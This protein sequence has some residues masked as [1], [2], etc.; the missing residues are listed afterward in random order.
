MDTSRLGWMYDAQHLLN[1]KYIL[2][3][4]AIK[5][6]RWDMGDVY[7]AFA[8]V[9][10][11]IWAECCRVYGMNMVEEYSTFTLWLLVCVCVWWFRRIR[12][13]FHVSLWITINKWKRHNTHKHTH[14]EMKA[15]AEQTKN[16]NNIRLTLATNTFYDMIYST[17]AFHQD[18]FSF[19]FFLFSFFFFFFFC[20]V[21]FK[22]G[23]CCFYFQSI[24][25][26]LARKAIYASFTIFSPL[27]FYQSTSNSISNFIT[28][29]WNIC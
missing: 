13:C 8:S 3:D 7:N 15:T 27:S 28:T 9:S 4:F 26:M 10:R 5:N 16:W 17:R 11:Q 14:D 25:D 12:T 19:L 23:C 20:F 24:N 18:S 22:N 1:Y 21:H 6:S 2:R 29:T